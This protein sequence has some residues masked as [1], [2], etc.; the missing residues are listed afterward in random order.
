LM[1]EGS[2]GHKMPYNRKRGG[3]TKRRTTR[4]STRRVLYPRGE[5]SMGGKLRKGDK[6]K[7]YPTAGVQRR[8]TVKGKRGAARRSGISTGNVRGVYA[9]GIRQKRA[10]ICCT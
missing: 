6:K 1:G 9:S 10:R 4:N 2:S 5:G 8:K 7:T 3:A